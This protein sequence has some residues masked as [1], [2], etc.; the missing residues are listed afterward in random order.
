[1]LSTL[2]IENSPFNEQQLR[3][4]KNSIGGLNPAQSQWLS[5]FLAGRLAESTHAASTLQSL[6]APASSLNVIY[7]TETG[8]SENIASELAASL[9]Q[10]G[11]SVELHSMDNFH[12]ATLRKLKN[13]AFVISTH[14]EGDPPDEA[15]ALFEYLE[16]ERAPRLPELNYRVLALGDRSYRLFCEAGRKLDSRLQALGA[17]PFGQRV[18]CDVDFASNAKA[19]NEEVI[20]YA[21]DNLATDKQSP[22]TAFSGSPHLSLV[23]HESLW[24]RRLPFAAEV[25]AIQ[26]I[27]GSGSDKD[28]YHLE[29]LLEDSGLQYQPGDALGVWAPNDP[30][31][32]DRILE[33][34]QVD[35][36]KPVHINDQQLRIKDALTDHL[37]IT[38]LA[39]DTVLAYANV[40]GQNQL[41]A[42]FSGLDA[43]QQQVFIKK[44]QLADLV[45]EYPAQFEPQALVELLRPLASRSYSIASSQQMVDEE[46]HLTVA[47]LHSN[48]IG[49]PRQGVASGLLNHRLEPGGKV[50][51][52]LE[53]NR[54]FRLPDDEDAPIIMIAAGT[55]IAPYRAF[56]QELEACSTKNRTAGPD[57][58]L[59]F[60]NPHLRTDFLYQREWLRWR[61]TG[62]LNRIDT[63]WSRDQAE[64]RYVQDLVVEQAERIDQWLQ[65]GAHIYLCG[66]LQM[67][68]AV[69]QG[70]QNALAQQRGIG[71]D[72][73]ATLL[74]ELRRERRI[75]KDL[76]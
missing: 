38:R 67:G 1:M 66:S 54:R 16:S 29:L 15:L 44:R 6:P 4:L 11:F 8:H 60:G 50:K 19:Y 51:V 61:D 39:T 76:Y 58:W 73:A 41:E 32:V 24:S 64:K 56:M 3:Q 5:G 25:G 7:A 33:I 53:P 49:K 69:Q 42:L 23:P 57:S 2:R 46:V 28:V 71:S 52:F 10:Q 21:R 34:L 9:E 59:I 65:R 43:D 37:E 20:Q 31:V 36:A 26:K 22:T 30:Q 62:L 74:A 47:T 18:E 12:P 13:V 55:G 17:R 48:A 63:A 40:G 27:T 72:A 14:G 70:L 45:D 68:Q 75:Q 35:P